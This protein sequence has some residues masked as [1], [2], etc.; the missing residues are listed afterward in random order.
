M[1]VYLNNKTPKMSIGDS[2]LDQ[3]GDVIVTHDF[4]A[5][6]VRLGPGY[7]L[8]DENGDQIGEGGDGGSGAILKSTTALT[9]A[10]IKALPTTPI[11]LIAAP[12][13]SKIT[14][15][16]AAFLRMHWVAD[17]ANIDA[18]A[19]VQI[20]SG[21][22]N[23]MNQLLET[24][25][26]PVSGLLAGGGPDGTSGWIGAQSR[27]LAVPTAFH[28]GISYLY[29]SDIANKPLNIAADNQGA[30]NFTGGN[31]GNVLT[32]TVLYTVIDF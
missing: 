17:Y 21:T 1:H 9:D 16:I 18:G 20:L 13:A 10:Q 5:K 7:T 2:I 27:S 12:G 8:L 4:D 24:A 29:D 19:I 31:A 26:S 23:V 32:V 28:Y 14:F 6:T 11:T 30:G 3:A 15:P 22:Q 25:G